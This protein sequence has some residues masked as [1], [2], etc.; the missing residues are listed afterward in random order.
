MIIEDLK[1]RKEQLL[2]SEKNFDAFFEL[3]IIEKLADSMNSV[4]EDAKCEFLSDEIDINNFEE[5]ASQLNYCFDLSYN[6]LEEL[7]VNF[8][9]DNEIEK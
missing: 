2:N 1:K 6:E 4:G 7:C 9:N 8:I 3:C 5:F